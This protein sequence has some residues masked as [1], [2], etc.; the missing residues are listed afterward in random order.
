MIKV[1]KNKKKKY[2]NLIFAFN[3]FGW[4]FGMFGLYGLIIEIPTYNWNETCGVIVKSNL[5]NTRLPSQPGYS[6]KVYVSYEYKVSG[7]KYISDKISGSVHIQLGI[8]IYNKKIIDRYP[9][10]KQINVYYDS[11][12]PENAVLIRGVTFE[13]KFFMVIAVLL[14]IT[15]C[16][17]NLY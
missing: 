7:K 10:G 8:D 6:K 14:F 15:A 5:V 12:E 16:K 4:I 9:V 17:L 1:S 11:N 13:T 2:G 3:V